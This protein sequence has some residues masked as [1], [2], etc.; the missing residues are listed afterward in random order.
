MLY[1]GLGLYALNLVVGLAARGG[2]RFGVW[3]HVLYAV[4]FVGAITAAIA[5]LR[6]A[7]LLTLA[8]LAIM[9]R[10]RP[11]TPWHPLVA[12]TG[13]GGYVGALLMGP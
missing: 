5:T 13:F 3:H 11:R 4:V 12:V 10:L 6:P 1:V 2:L 8:A 9:P 7:L